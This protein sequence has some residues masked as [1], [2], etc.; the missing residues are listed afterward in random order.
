MAVARFRYYHERLL[1]ASAVED[2]MIQ[3]KVMRIRDH[4]DAANAAEAGSLTHPEEIRCALDLHFGEKVAVR[5]TLRTTPAGL[6]SAGI[7]ASATL[8]ALAALV[9]TARGGSR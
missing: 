7:M 2:S 3:A 5:T 6:I 1:T 8:L 4:A 9:R